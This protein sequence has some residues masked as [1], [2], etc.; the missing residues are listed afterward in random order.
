MLNV[1]EQVSK[2]VDDRTRHIVEFLRRNQVN[3]WADAVERAFMGP[4]ES[5]ETT[6]ATLDDLVDAWESGT[7][8]RGG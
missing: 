4:I 7:Q 5:T 1:I 2:A 3:Q 8:R 6:F